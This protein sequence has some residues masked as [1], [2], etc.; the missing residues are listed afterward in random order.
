ML[1][2]NLIRSTKEFLMN[3]DR[4]CSVVTRHRKNVPPSAMEN[5]KVNWGHLS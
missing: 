2:G 1:R 3:Y 5:K 4:P